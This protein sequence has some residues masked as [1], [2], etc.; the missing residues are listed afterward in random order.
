MKPTTFRDHFSGDSDKYRKYRPSYP[1]ELFQYLASI[2]PSTDIAWDCA[3]GSGQA[4]IQLAKYFSSVIATDASRQQIQHAES[5]KNVIYKVAQA[6]NTSLLSGSTDLVTVA[7]ALHWFDYEQF[8]SEV[9]RVLKDGGV[10]AVW[11]YNLLTL[12]PELDEIIKELYQSVVGGYWPIERKQ[13]ETGYKNIFFPF[14]QI[15]APSFNMSTEWTLKELKGYL[16]TW[17]AVKLFVEDKGINPI[18]ILSQKLSD[19]WGD[20]SKS[21]KVTW[22]LSLIIGTNST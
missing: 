14:P 5:A 16:G 10:I 7:Q 12:T 20:P 17:S 9:K 15:K 19:N 4:A 1:D 2:S 21:L 3:T 8:F 22:P 13:V 6:E 18:E 11:S